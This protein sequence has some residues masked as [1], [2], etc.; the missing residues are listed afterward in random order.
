MQR[1]QERI[2][3]THVGSLIRPPQLLEAAAARASG[4]PDAEATYEHVLRQS[5]ADVVRQ[6]AAAGIDVPSDGEYGKS[7][8]FFYLLERT[9]GFER[10]T[11]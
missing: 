7:G 1:S 9:S 10:C 5:V 4:Q 8:W 2:L 6:Q 3:T 11:L